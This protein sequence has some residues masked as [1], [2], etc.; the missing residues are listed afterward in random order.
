MIPAST[1]ID[2]PV[3]CPCCGQL[4]DHATWWER[5]L[6]KSHGIMPC[7]GKGLTGDQVR[8]L[9]AEVRARRAAGPVGIVRRPVADRVGGPNHDVA[10]KRALDEVAREAG[11]G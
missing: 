8:S 9:I 2:N 11:R 4:L 5:R 1:L 6:E 10:I 7:C 3:Q